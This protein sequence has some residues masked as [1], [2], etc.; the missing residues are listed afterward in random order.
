VVTANDD[1]AHTYVTN[2]LL[3]N[4]RSFRILLVE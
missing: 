2:S 3:E 1:V 4:V